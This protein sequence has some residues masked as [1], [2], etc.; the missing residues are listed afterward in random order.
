MT[1][2][3]TTRSAS[4]STTTRVRRSP[5]MTGSAALNLLEEDRTTSTSDIVGCCSS[6]SP[7]T[8]MTMNTNTN[9]SSMGCV[10][11]GVDNGCS[12]SP[13]TTDSH[14][15]TTTVSSSSVIP[16]GPIRDTAYYVSTLC[17]GVGSGICS[18]IICA[19][20]DLVRTRLQVWGNLVTTTT[21]TSS[22][23]AAATA[24]PKI[25]TTPIGVI[26]DILQREG[27]KGLFRGLG[28][29]MVTVP[30]FWG[31][32]FPLYEETKHY[33]TTN[34]PQ[35]NPALVHCGSA[36]FTGAV[37]DVLCNPLFL[38]RTRLQT[39]AMHQPS[40]LSS[41][42][43]VQ[44]AMEKGKKQSS[45]TTQLYKTNPAPPPP[46]PPT[47]TMRHTAIS[48]Y[49]THGLTVFWRGMS[50]NLMGLSHVAIQFP[51]YEFLKSVARQRRQQE[52]YEQKR[53]QR[54]QGGNDYDDD[55][56]DD[57]VAV[58]SALD[59]LI[60]SGLAKMCASL[61]SYPHEVLRS[62]MMDSRA[63][64]T[65]TLM[66]TFT[67]IW[68]TEGPKGFYRGLPITLFRVIPN[69]CITFLSYEYLK[70]WSQDYYQQWQQQQQTTTQPQQ[71]RTQSLR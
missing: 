13:S 2:P 16:G 56:D 58:E 14:T 7:T 52:Q 67:E 6:S 36:V 17:A 41:T 21:T 38:I 28:A 19:P 10:G 47:M 53:Q 22:T 63:T 37:A 69:C 33:V 49:Q 59:L 24:I 4:S 35:T 29:T 31:V 45:S 12:R 20:L 11:V 65:P 44:Q 57:E 62:R 55:F 61:I 66:G 1:N 3:T 26:Q 60:A 9:S 25:P 8:T 70:R 39:Q 30:L 64:M 51:T 48:L 42:S 23:T 5:T 68:N 50:A 18:S 40:E 34:Y 71:Q 43:T 32:Y 27:P 46:P 54:L 15:T